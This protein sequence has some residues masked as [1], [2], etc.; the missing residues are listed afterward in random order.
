MK[1]N[2]FFILIVI[3]ISLVLNGCSTDQASDEVIEKSVPITVVTVEE[4][5]LNETFLSLGRVEAKTSV[6]VQTGGLGIVESIAVKAGDVVSKDQILFTLDRE[7]LQADY[8]ITES[9]LRTNRDNLK[10]QLSD[11]EEEVGQNEILYNNQAISKKVLEK[12]IASLK[13]IEN[14]Y[15]NA[16]T[17][18]NTRLNNLNDDI[19]SRK[20]K[21]PIEGRV[22]AV[23]IEADES[24]QN[25]SAVEIIND[26][27]VIAI[28]DVTANQVNQ[29]EINGPVIVFPDGKSASECVGSIVRFNEIPEDARGLYEVEVLICN[30][31]GN[32][33]TGQYI[34]VYYIIDQ[35]RV[36]MA[37]KSA[38]KKVGEDSV[39]YVIENNIA[40]ERIVEVGIT[41]DESVEVI[42]G[43]KEGEIIALRG[44]SYLKDEDQIKIIK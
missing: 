2:I 30:K 24:V 7:D 17:N 1:K 33:R 8:T 41:Q 13:Q 38:I 29:L 36:L 19:E 21:S 11:M 9:Q 4:D 42:K 34:E 35:R 31:D 10:N 5:D 15:N 39:V 22:A 20:V 26:D 43:V 16:V 37:P 14:Q 25:Q 23:Y 3:S 27:E 28:T 44:S 18:Y 12:S 40:K 32:L 6:T